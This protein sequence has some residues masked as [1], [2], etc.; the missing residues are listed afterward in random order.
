MRQF[1]TNRRMSR[2]HSNMPAAVV[3]LCC[4]CTKRSS[5]PATVCAS[6]HVDPNIIKAMGMGRKLRHGLRQ[7]IPDRRL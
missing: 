3:W 4:R 5:T 6:P 1:P 2:P 7:A